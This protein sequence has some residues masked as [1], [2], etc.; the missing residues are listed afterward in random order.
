MKFKVEFNIDNDAFVD[1]CN[2][3]IAEIL[4]DIAEGMKYTTADFNRDIVLSDYNGNSI[5]NAY[6]EED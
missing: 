2:T 6:F 5:G 1:D 4:E 3:E